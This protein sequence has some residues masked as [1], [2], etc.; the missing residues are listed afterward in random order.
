MYEDDPK[1][2][3]ITDYRPKEKESFPSKGKNKAFLL[4][5]KKAFSLKRKLSFQRKKKRLF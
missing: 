1:I 4:K 3:D 5:E 2:I